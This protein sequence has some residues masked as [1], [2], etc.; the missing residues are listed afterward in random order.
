M[1]TNKLNL[2]QSFVN[3]AGS[4]NHE[5]KPNRYSVTELLKSTQEIYLSRKYDVDTDVSEIIPALFGSAVHHILEANT[6]TSE[7]LLPEYSIECELY[8]ITIS[9]RIDLL[10]LSELTIEDYK[11]CSTS[12]KDYEDWKLQGL[13]YAYLVYL[14]K[15]IKIKQLRFYAIYKDWSKIRAASSS[16]YPQN[17]VFTWTYNIDDSDFIYIDEWLKTKI[18]DIKNEN[19]YCDKWYTGDKYAVYKSRTDKRATIVCDSEQEAHDYI[20]NKLNGAGIIDVRK[21]EN[22]KCKY[23]CKY[24]KECKL[25]D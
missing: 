24:C 15:D 17:P 12:K 1:I 10:N 19:L 25:N 8:G 23:Y 13:I 3:Y 16:G 5:H 21:G 7:T 20:T 22:I 14:T 18:S 4:D 9:G 11:T 6:V 2:P